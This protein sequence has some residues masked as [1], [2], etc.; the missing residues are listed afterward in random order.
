MKRITRRTFMTG[1][2]AVGAAITLPNM[3]NAAIRG[4]NEDIRMAVVGVGGQGS[5]HCNIFS[6]LK[7]VRLVAV[8]DADQN[9]T[10]RR[11]ND[12]KKQGITVKGYRDVRKLLENKDIDAISSAT[13]NHWHSLVTIWACQAGKDVYIEKPVSH[14]IW[15]GRK[16]IEAARKYNRIVQTGTQKRSSGAH[17]EAFEYIHQGN[18]GK[19][20]LARGL[21]YKLRSSIG[22][23][24]G[25]QPIPAGVDYNQWCGPSAYTPLRRKRLHYDWHWDFETGNGDIGNQGVHEMDLCRWALGQ[26][27]LAPRVWSFGGR[28]GYIDDANTPNTLVTFLDYKPVPLIFEVRGLPRSKT[29]KAQSIYRGASIGIV[30]QCEGGYFAAGNAGGWIYDNDGKKIKQFPGDGGRGHHA[31]FIKAV[32]SRKVSDLNADIVEGHLSAALCH[33]GDISYRIGNRS[34]PD[35]IKEACKGNSDMLDS[36]ER[37]M[38]HLAVNDADLNMTPA[39]LGP[40]LTMDKNTEKFTGEHS[41]YA[42]MYLKRNYRRE[43]E[44]PEKV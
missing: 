30:I 43:F 22:N 31:N 42:N 38:K 1:T 4:A 18:I 14:N 6:K 28:F 37:C 2:L 7:G 24:K 33:M 20:L 40:M 44:V 12:F 34:N 35:E 8:C 11:V 21:C 27:E 3:A 39:V 32:R 15:E 9:H 23:V 16:M 36:L 13:P 10:D 29:I 26:Q 41:V 17:K 5:N 25:P 19:M